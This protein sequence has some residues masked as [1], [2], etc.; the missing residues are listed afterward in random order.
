MKSNSVVGKTSCGSVCI[1]RTVCNAGYCYIRHNAA[2]SAHVFV[3]VS[4]ACQ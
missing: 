2:W 3:F 1:V 4:L